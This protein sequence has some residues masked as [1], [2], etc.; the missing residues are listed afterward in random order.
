MAAD[1]RAIDLGK[2]KRYIKNR[3]AEFYLSTL[4]GEE[5]ETFQSIINYLD[6]VRLAK[7]LTPQYDEKEV[8]RVKNLLTNFSPTKEQYNIINAINKRKRD[9]NTKLKRTKT[10]VQR[11]SI[12]EKSTF[13]K[14]SDAFWMMKTSMDEE[15]KTLTS[16]E[17]EVIKKNMLLFTNF[18][19][20]TLNERVKFEIQQA[21]KQ[22]EEIKARI[23]RLNSKIRL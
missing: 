14:I 8:E 1:K 3:T 10:K 18:I 7:D 4:Q 5:K 15:G 13:E 12:P 2:I 11:P 17:L 6:N 22:A 21:Q 16:K 23:E 9:E 20:S 19:D